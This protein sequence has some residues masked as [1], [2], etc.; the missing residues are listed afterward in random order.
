M[1]G[2]THESFHIAS[3]EIDH[4]RGPSMSVVAQN[5]FDHFDCLKIDNLPELNQAV[6]ANPQRELTDFFVIGAELFR[7]SHDDLMPF[8]SFNRSADNFTGKRGAD[9]LIH[10]R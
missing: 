7:H 8:F 2:V 6:L 9:R 5:R 3:A 4:Q 10:F 1:F